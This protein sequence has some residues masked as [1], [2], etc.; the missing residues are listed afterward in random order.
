MTNWPLFITL[1]ENA[2][3]QGESGSSGAISTPPPGNRR[4]EAR[5]SL[6]R[7]FT[8]GGRGGVER[9]S[10][11]TR[12]SVVGERRP[13]PPRLLTGLSP[14]TRVSISCMSAFIWRTSSH[15]LALFAFI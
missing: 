15:S 2:A 12:A 5:W 14:R 3:L 9:L 11:A 10:M 8:P 7:L 4:K 13:V 1:R 6:G